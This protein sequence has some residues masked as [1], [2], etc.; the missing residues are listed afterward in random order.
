VKC[1][2]VCVGRSGVE[3]SRSS[4]SGDQADVEVVDFETE[5]RQLEA[6]VKELKQVDCNLA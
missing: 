5:Y 1:S 6:L 3:D 4:T 2:A